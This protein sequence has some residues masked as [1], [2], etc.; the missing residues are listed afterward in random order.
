[1]KYTTLGNTDIKVSEFAVGC[2]PFA[3]GSVWGAQDDGVSISTVHAALDH[4][5][6]FFDT[7]EGY[8]D[9][10]HSEEVLGKALKYRREHAVIGTKIGPA[11]LIPTGIRETCEASLKR[12]GTDYIDLYQIHWPNHDVDVSKSLKV[13]ED[14]RVEGKIR[15]IG[16]CNFGQKDLGD[17]AES[18]EIVTNQLPYYLLWRAIEQNILPL[19]RDKGIGLICY[20]PLAQGL[21]TGRYSSADEVPDGLSRSRLFSRNRPLA[22]HGEEGCEKDAF[23]AIKKIVT[24]AYELGEHPA[25]VSLAWVRAQDGITSLLVGAR[26]PDELKLNLPAFDYKLSDDIA[27]RLSDS[28]HAVKQY[29][30]DNAD[31]WNGTN[32]MR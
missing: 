1:M 18:V 6:N 23:E 14:L 10:S 31:M 30:G 13:L 9:D 15:A 3:G 25:T 4:G 8:N 2:W 28:T 12:L 27:E 32:R 21:L 16:V 24:I 5:I 7:A 17:A 22:V 19:C 29:L 11:N 26:S 20:S